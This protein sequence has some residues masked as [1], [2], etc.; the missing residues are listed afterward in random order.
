MEEKEEN[1][2][3]NLEIVIIRPPLV[4]GP[5]VK[6]NFLKLLEFV[7]K[8]FPLPFLSINN[9]RSMIYVENL[10]SFI[11]VCLDNGKAKNKTFIVSV[12]IFSTFNHAFSKIFIIKF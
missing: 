9:K 8:G 3:E 11:I 2:K 6:A 7:Y 12:N 10:V 1:Q 4:Y 5:N